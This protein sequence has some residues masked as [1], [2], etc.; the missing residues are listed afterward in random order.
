MQAGGQ[1]TWRAAPAVVMADNQVAFDNPL[2]SDDDAPSDVG[3]AAG[4]KP[5]NEAEA[6]VPDPQPAAS[7]RN[8]EVA[9]Y[10]YRPPGCT[11]CS[12]GEAR[13]YTAAVV[14]V[15]VFAV[16]YGLASANGDGLQDSL[17]PGR[18]YHGEPGIGGCDD[19]AVCCDCD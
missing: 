6:S 17:Q 5:A 15:L 9:A 3:G 4:N 2:A 7:E 19:P 11:N 10:K 12:N 1:G 14:G 13:F 18:L 8:L 16:V